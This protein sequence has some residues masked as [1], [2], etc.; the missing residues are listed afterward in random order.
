MAGDA[1][2]P[3]TWLARAAGQSGGSLTPPDKKPR[4]APPAA[5]AQA[6]NAAIV[7]AITQGDSKSIGGW[8][9]ACVDAGVRFAEGG[10]ARVVAP[11]GPR[12]SDADSR[13]PT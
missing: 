5:C 8:I 12:P 6:V 3:T 13:R 11:E 10:E 4:P 2:R 7:L 9:K 1:K